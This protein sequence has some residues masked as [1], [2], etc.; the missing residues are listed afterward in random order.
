MGLYEA[1]KPLLPKGAVW[2]ALMIP[3]TAAAFF[4]TPLAQDTP[5][6][7]PQPWVKTPK[8]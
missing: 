3:T 8:E 2:P 4:L 7:A 5:Q 1:K 6:T